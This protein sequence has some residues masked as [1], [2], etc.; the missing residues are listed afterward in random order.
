M[1]QLFVMAV[2]KIMGQEKNAL[3]T[4]NS[5]LNTALVKEIL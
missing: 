1:S 2:K 5:L 4:K 3:K